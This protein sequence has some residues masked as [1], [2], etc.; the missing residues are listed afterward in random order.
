[1]PITIDSNKTSLSYAEEAS[2]STLPA[3]PTWHPLEP[4]SYSSFGGDLKTTTREPITATR[5]RAK[6]TV[7]DLDVTAAF[8]TD[9]TQD[10]LTRLLQGFFFAKAH[11]KFKTQPI[12]GTAIALTGAVAAS[13]EITA[14]AGLGAVAIDTLI[15]PSG[16]ANAANN[17]LFRVTAAAAGEL[18]L[19]SYVSG[20]AAV[21]LVDEAAPPAAALL[22]AV[23]VA[24]H[25]DVLLYG[26]GSNGG[27]TIQPYLSS[28]ANVDFTTLGLLPGEWVY[29]GDADD[30]LG[31][32]AATEY[33]FLS[34]DGTKRNR[35]YCRILSIAP[36]KLTF[37]IAIGA[38]TWVQGSGANGS[39]PVPASGFVSLYFGTVI[40]NEPVAANIV[41]T[42]YTLQ[43]FLG[44]N[45][46]NQS[47]LEYVSGAVPNEFSLTIPSNNKLTSDLTFV[48][49]DTQQEA[50]AQLPG[51]YLGLFS[52][53]AFNTSQDVFALLLY[54]I[55]AAQTQQQP[56]FAYATDQKITINNNT[57]PNK[58]IGVV[59]AIEASVGNFD[60][61]GTLTCYFDD[62]AAIQA[63]R[64]NTDVGLTNIFAKQ[65]SGMIIDLPLLT[66]AMPGVKVE[67]DKP[68]MADITQT[69]APR[70]DATNLLYYTALY[71]QFTY[72]PASAMAD[73]AG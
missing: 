30:T 37:D 46:D 41:R 52:E 16:F 18:T 55:D 58:A 27:A 72:L 15:K 24:L 66:L 68:I 71:N 73:Y 50:I 44:Q 39:C 5:Q 31:D 13:Q 2:L 63:V 64:N 54:I 38:Q 61:S 35:G 7:T 4:N 59:G 32:A 12:N 19:A 48:G 57:K 20:G 65:N 21:P 67:K 47:Q 49:M 10:N 70:P 42:T 62:I 51:T 45:A 1:M 56:L 43:R 25:G 34:A 22:E 29:L 8:N 23:G 14:A 9:V 40:R 60:V 11:E 33:N 28:A 6:G 69:A 53:P 3:N 36:T 26:P 17:G